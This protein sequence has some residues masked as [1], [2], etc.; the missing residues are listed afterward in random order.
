[1]QT[2]RDTVGAGCCRTHSGRNVTPSSARR[3]TERADGR[4]DDVR[5]VSVV[6]AERVGVRAGVEHQFGLADEASLDEHAMAVNHPERR[7]RADLELGVER[8]DL[9]L[10]REPKRR[11]PHQRLER[12]EIDRVVCG[13]DGL[14]R[15]GSRRCRSP[16]WPS[17]DP[18]CG[19]RR[20][21]SGAVN[22]GGCRRVRYGTRSRFRTSARQASKATTAPFRPGMDGI[23]WPA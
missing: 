1:M 18:E 19:R 12:L 6:H 14:H 2:T 20:T 8:G 3:H 22:A 7:H 21:S 13:Q 11:T 17:V 23:A 4:V 9:L 16:P 5:E 10:P 15:L